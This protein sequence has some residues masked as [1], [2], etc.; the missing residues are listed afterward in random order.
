MK[1]LDELCKATGT[2]AD[3]REFLE[4]PD[5]GFGVVYW[6]Q[7]AMSGKKVCVNDDQGRITVD[8][9]D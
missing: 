2:R 7:H 5:S 4:G 6:F 1:A 9:E 8:C 3:E